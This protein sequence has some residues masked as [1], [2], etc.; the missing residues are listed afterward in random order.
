MTKVSRTLVLS[1][2]IVAALALSGCKS[3][4]EKAE[5]YYQSGLALLAKGDEERAM[6]EFRNVFKYDGFHKDARKTYADTLLKEGKEQ[7]AYSQYLRLIEQYPDTAEVR[8]TLAELAITRGDWTEA[9]RHGRAA[10]ALAPDVPGVQAIKLAL[11]YRAAVMADDTA[12]RDKIAAAAQ[13]FLV[14]QPANLIALRIVID[15]MAT[16]PNP[17]LAIP[18]LDDA[19]KADP[20]SL[21]FHMLKF[22]LLA[23]A[24]DVKGTGEQLKTM[25]DLFPEND[26]VKTALIGWYIVQ[27]DF[28]GAE[29]FLRKLASDPTGPADTHL[30][31]VQFL[32]SARGTDAARAELDSLIT[33]NTGNANAQLYGA[34]RAA[35]DFQT[36]QRPEAVAALQAIVKGAEPSDQTRRIKAILAQMLD[37][38]GNRVGA[39]SLVEEVLAEDPA[40][41]DALKLRAAWFIDEDKPG[42][43]IVDLR[44][45]LD[46]SPRDPSILTLMAA[47]HERDGSLDLAGQQLARAVEVSGAGPGESL[48]YAQFLMRQN[49]GQVAETVLVNARRVSPNNPDIL[50]ATAQYYMSLSQWP[51]AQEAV[52]TLKALNLPDA[53]SGVPELQAA[54][55]AGQNRLDASLALLQ[56]Q[57]AKGSQGDSAVVMIVQT[58]VQAGK[59]AEARA[60]LD[61]ALQKDPDNA[62]F[63]LLG[64]SLDQQMAKPDAAAATYRG[65]IAKDPA[66]DVPVRLLYALLVTSGKTDEAAQVLDAGLAA[67]PKST[68]LRWI[69]AGL[70]EQDGKIEEA[71]AV[72][73]GLYAENSTNTVVANNLASLITAHHDDEASLKRAEAIARRLRGLEVPAFQDTYG[74]IALRTGNLDDA[75]SHLEPAAKGLPKDAL[76]QFHLGML[77]DK[78][79]R[80][81]DAI[82]QFELAL[83]LAGAT[84]AD[85]IQPQMAI[86]RQAVDRLKAAPAP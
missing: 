14:G 34:M 5:D 69:K 80:K 3:S 84:P 51:Q 35:L 7:E 78:L 45:A 44:A 46:Q 31:L 83:S 20:K 26:S 32:Q 16:G 63:L 22:R 74:W 66:N 33:A 54:L 2:T 4:K 52:D 60:Y 85:A 48:R 23:Q 6:I 64:A 18:A 82:R 55:Y 43:A 59:L 71:I 67:L 58:Q 29:A 19:L 27:K 1:L 12:A 65:L 25:F 61:G 49:Q 9:D 39:R 24:E 79:G 73:D 36:G 17:L 21:E 53:M 28:D 42:D 11:D 56:E 68:D 37:E 77:Y 8:Q 76:A 40:N 10:I 15:R 13:A 57:V 50:R 86:A 62:T 75:L 81:D 70:L 41:V 47:A 38:T 30:A 72:Y